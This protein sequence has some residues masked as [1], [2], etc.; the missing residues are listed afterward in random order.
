MPCE[1]CPKRAT[2]HQICP[3]L[4]AKLPRLHDTVAHGH[5]CNLERVRHVLDLREETGEILG[6]RTRLDGREREVVDLV[7][8]R[9]LTI[10]EVARRLHTSIAAVRRLLGHAYDRAGRASVSSHNA[11]RRGVR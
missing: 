1:S 8:N 7:F 3:A 4:E 11:G 10:E 9:S 6:L 2:C 5:G